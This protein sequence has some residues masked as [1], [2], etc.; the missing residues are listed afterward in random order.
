[1]AETVRP[2]RGQ[3]EAREDYAFELLSRALHKSQIKT[4]FQKKF[5]C[6][7]R[8]VERYL[9]RAR[10]RM[11]EL[12]GKSKEEH[13]QEALAFYLSCLRHPEATVK[14]KVYARERIDK[15]LGL[16]APQQVQQKTEH[17]GAIA[18][19]V[20]VINVF[21]AQPEQQPEADQS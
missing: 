11:I 1:M 20:P 9:A 3:E 21:A 17:S 5:D 13:R 7:A 16:D 19:I 14:E 12:S 8:T 10:A 2:T 6:S 18:G 15:L 4:L